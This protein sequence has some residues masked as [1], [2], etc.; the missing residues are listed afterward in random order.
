MSRR[1]GG[2][3]MVEL[4]MV[5]IIL[6]ILASVA[7]P[8]FLN[9][10]AEALDASRKGVVGGLNSAIQIVHSRWLAQ[11]ATGTVTP[12]GGTAITMIAAGNPNAGYP[13]IPATYGN[14]QNCATLVGSLLLGPAPSFAADC[15]GVTVPLRIGFSAGACQVNSCPTNFATPIALSPTKAE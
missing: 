3:T 4:I 6:G 1:A 8:R 11:G 10:N 13:D 9:M 14:A 7:V 5:I 12:D 2:F 15:T